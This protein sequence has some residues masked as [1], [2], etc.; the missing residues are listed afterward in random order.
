MIVGDLGISFL[1]LCGGQENSSLGDCEDPWIA[2]LGDWEG[3][4]WPQV[5]VGTE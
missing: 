3:E 5:I 1:G 4:F 2:T